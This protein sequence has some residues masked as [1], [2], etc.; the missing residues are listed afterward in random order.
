MTATGKA[1]YP[2]NYDIL[3]FT[4]ARTVFSNNG[5]YLLPQAFPEDRRSIL[6]TRKVKRQW[7]GR[8]PRSSKLP[9]T[10]PSNSTD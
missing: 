8:A 5:T 3:K 9:L 7:P 6:P 10:A 2:L 4:A 1:H